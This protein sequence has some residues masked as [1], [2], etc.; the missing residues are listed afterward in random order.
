VQEGYWVNDEFSGA[1]WADAFETDSAKFEFTNNEISTLAE[2]HP[3]KIEGD[4]SLYPLI[5]LPYDT[6]RLTSGYVAT[7]PFLV[8]TLEDSVLNGNDVLVEINPETA[9]PLGLSEGKTAS[10]TTI[11]GSARV[12][13]HLTHGI[14]PGV[15]GIPRGLGRMT[16]DR[17]L[18][19][20]GVSYNQLSGEVEDP[21]SGHNAAWGIR[22]KLSK[23]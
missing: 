10:L 7:P 23:A 15:I 22:A 6:M 4:E 13:V 21:A 17:F 2:Y 12:K 11:K 14:M 18:T 3:V 8:K 16:D 19:G 1:G 5:L 20:R 9:K